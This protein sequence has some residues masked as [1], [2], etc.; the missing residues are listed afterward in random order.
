MKQDIELNETQERN[1][2]QVKKR[3]QRHQEK[4]EY[5]SS[6]PNSMHIAGSADTTGLKENPPK[7][8]QS[9]KHAKSIS[10]DLEKRLQKE[11][12]RQDRRRQPK[13]QQ[14]KRRSP[15]KRRKPEKRSPHQTRWR[16]L[17]RP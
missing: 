12:P 14:K 4:R 7:K 15:K 6:E 1:I 13:K 10:E 8:S 9:P 2:N 16:Q 17:H 5:F 11:K 3:A